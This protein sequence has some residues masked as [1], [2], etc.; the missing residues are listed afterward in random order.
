VGK[1]KGTNI[2]EETTQAGVGFAGSLGKVFETK[3][4]G[5]GA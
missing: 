3:G 1:S 4:E 5:W 2:S